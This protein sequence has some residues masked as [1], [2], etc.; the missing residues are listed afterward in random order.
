MLLLH[1]NNNLKQQHF[2]HTERW[3][4]ENIRFFGGNPDLV[5][6]FG[7]S[8]G[9]A[10]VHHH[11][12]APHSKGNQAKKFSLSLKTCFTIGTTRLISSS[13]RTV[14]IST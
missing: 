8:S 3:V 7:E 1:F 9:G 10:S 6:I 5:T 14:G 4:N 13:D 2:L 12:F 11:L